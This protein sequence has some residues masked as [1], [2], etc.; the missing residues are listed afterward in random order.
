MQFNLKSTFGLYMPYSMVQHLHEAD[1]LVSSL[2]DEMSEIK[3]QDKLRQH[4][5][6]IRERHGDDIAYSVLNEW[7]KDLHEYKHYVDFSGTSFGHHYQRGFFSILA[8]FFR[9]LLNI[10]T[11]AIF[12]PLSTWSTK[13]DCPQNVREWVREYNTFT[14]V[15][16]SVLGDFPV[17]IPYTNR[18]D[19]IVINYEYGKLKLPT[20]VY[21]LGN[22]V[23]YAVGAINL[24]ET[25][26][27]NAQHRL[28]LG[29]LGGDWWWWLAQLVA[30]SKAGKLTYCIIALINL[31]ILG[32]WCPH[33]DYAV[34][35]YSL[36]GKGL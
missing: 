21:T 5:V 7:T 33:L 14:D 1:P 2:S 16:N 11:D 15:Y 13:S 34:S 19:L 35:D 30:S 23:G 17:H 32:K 10:E 18:N 36:M 8:S 29:A 6:R 27:I 31:S 12:L 24:F 3:E 28:I 20:V 26:A 4:L 25:L 9:V 22:S